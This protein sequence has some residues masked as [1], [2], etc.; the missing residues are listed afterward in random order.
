[1]TGGRSNSVAVRIEHLDEL[2]VVP[3]PAPRAGT[4]QGDH[5]PIRD[6]AIACDDDGVIAAAGTTAEVRAASPGQSDLRVISG[7][8]RSLVPGFVDAHTHVV[9]AGDRRGELRERLA[10]ASYAD[11]AAAGGGILSTV[12]ATRAASDTELA[13]ATRA[14]LAEMLA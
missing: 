6:G 3:G 14:R 13:D 9:F 5:V 10:G 4:R 2:Y 11:I 8:G 7:R 1:M 12:R